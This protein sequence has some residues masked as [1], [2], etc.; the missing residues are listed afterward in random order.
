MTTGNIDRDGDFADSILP[1]EVVELAVPVP[2]VNLQPWHRPRKQ[3]IRERQW[4]AYAKMLVKK[5]LRTGAPTIRSGRVNYLTLPGIDYFD[6][7]V[8]GEVVAECGLELE[9]MGL[10]ADIDKDPVKARSQVRSDTLVKRGIITDTSVTYPYRFEELASIGSQ[11]Y[12]EAKN[13]APFHIINVDACGSLAPPRVQDATRIIDALFRLVELQCRTMTDPWILYITTDVREE[14]LS[15][16]MKTAVDK[17]IRKN[18][19]NSGEFHDGVLGCVGEPGDDLNEALTRAEKTPAR[20][21]TKFSLGFAKWLIHNA[22]KEKWRVKCRR[23]FCYSTKRR[24]DAEV[25]MPCLAF[26]F[27]PFPVDMKDVHGAVTLKTEERG[28]PR[29]YSMEALKRAC[30][31]VNVDE[32][33]AADAGL[34][35]EFATKQRRL[36]EDAGY[37]SEALQQYDK[38]FLA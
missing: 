1:E 27:R 19:Q 4:K 29:E 33:L 18:A 6:V 38:R 30:E 15:K 34:M 23:F 12:R 21:V 7:E 36:L 13:R 8:L 26:E 37:Q 16:D 5:L 9:A 32:L 11:A 2:L 17:A 3:F 31:M 24:V 10:L 22:R 20:F 35:R 14:N 25:S 28:K